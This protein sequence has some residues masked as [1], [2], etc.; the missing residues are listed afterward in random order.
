MRE[1]RPSS[2]AAEEAA[3]WVRSY[4]PP[5]FAAMTPNPVALH[6]IFADLS[7]GGTMFGTRT[8]LE[9]PAWMP[10]AIARQVG[11]PGYLRDENQQLRRIVPVAFTLATPKGT[12]P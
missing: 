3:A 7:A 11:Q 10:A 4:S 9:R 6:G 12:N 2:N 1:H 8:T 5:A